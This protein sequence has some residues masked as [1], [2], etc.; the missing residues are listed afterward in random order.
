MVAAHN[1]V[2]NLKL[3]T[4]GEKRQVLM[5]HLEAKNKGYIPLSPICCELYCENSIT[6]EKAK[7]EI[8]FPL[9][10][11]ANHDIIFELESVH[12]GIMTV[13][14]K[15]LKVYDAL[16]LF[17]INTTNVKQVEVAVLPIT[18]PIH[19]TVSTH[20]ARD[21]EA[22]EYSQEKPGSDTSETFA[23]RDYQPGD[24]LRRI[25]WKLSGKF[26]ELLIKEP[27]LPVRHSFMVLLETNFK[28]GQ[29]PQVEVLDTLIEI[30]LS[31]G[32]AM[33][34]EEITYDIGWQD[35]EN[36]SFFHATIKSAEE[37]TG[38]VN[39]LLHIRYQEDDNDALDCFTE[40]YADNNFEHVIYIS[41]FVSNQLKL[42]SNE[43]Q[44]TGI[45]CNGEAANDTVMVEG[46]F[47]LYF[48]SPQNYEKELFALEI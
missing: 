37:L 46:A 9:G 21:V 5:C 20:L 3:P 47:N 6:G 26:D 24:S 19:L 17:S 22:D 15:A 40:V 38:V 27:G 33:T 30:V 8:T 18:F 28:S 43:S 2:A 48:C 13:N 35:H 7:K 39:R 32:Q 1:I 31:L 34:N 25:H 36:G 11:K 10:I 29:R 14:I 44:T 23:I 41:P 12:C 45:I 16:G 42:L 4:I